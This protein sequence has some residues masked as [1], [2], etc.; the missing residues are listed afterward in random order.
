MKRP[1]E[2]PDVVDVQI[3]DLHGGNVTATIK[4]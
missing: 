4:F 1:E 3:D 2:C